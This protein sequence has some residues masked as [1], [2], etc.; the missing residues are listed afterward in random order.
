MEDKLRRS[1]HDLEQFAYVASHDLS[2]PLRVISGFVE[3]L[4]R[5]YGQRLDEEGERFI[6]FIVS[7]V[8]RMQ[9]LIDDLLAYSRAGR[10]TLEPRDC[11]AAAVVSDLL[12][13]LRPELD[14]RGV[15]VQVG[16]LPT[17]KAEKSLLRQ[18]FQ[19]LIT[20]A[21]KFSDTEESVVRIR[22]ERIPGGWRFDVA[23]NGPGI[24]PR[25]RERIFEMFQRLHGR[26]VAGSGIGLA[27]VKRLVERHGGRVWASDADPRG[28]V[29]SFTIPDRAAAS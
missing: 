4:S 16:E 28:A 13:A 5:R 11:D 24:E 25:Y 6:E 14:A 23:D 21:V 1:N 3:L 17:V 15:D 29:F 19:N 10:A 7:G 26:D 20:N 9:T 12:R 2:E 27:I 8:E 18:I 22:A